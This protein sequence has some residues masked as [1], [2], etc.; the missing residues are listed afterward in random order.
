MSHIRGVHPFFFWLI[1]LGG[2]FLTDACNS[3][4][5]WYLGYWASQY[6]HYDPSEVSVP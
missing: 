4:Q 5:T 3:V 6:E 1:V 2:L